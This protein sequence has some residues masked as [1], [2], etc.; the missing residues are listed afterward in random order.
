M[1]NP[2]LL[3]AATASLALAPLSASAQAAAPQPAGGVDDSVARCHAQANAA[4]RTSCR[5][6]LAQ[7]SPRR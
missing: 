1:K 7:P 3:F 2:R 6:R 5:D 4:E